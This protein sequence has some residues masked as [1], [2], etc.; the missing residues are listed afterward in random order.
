LLVYLLCV[1][2]CA[3]CTL[4]IARAWR[5]TGTRLLFWCALCF[6]FLTINKHSGRDRRHPNAGD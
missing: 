3:T 2:T 6:F 4:L 5:R 1:V